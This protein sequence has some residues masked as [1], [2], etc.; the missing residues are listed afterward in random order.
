[1]LQRLNFNTVVALGIVALGA[2]ML[3]VIPNQIAEPPRFFGRSS[4]GLSPKLFPQIVASLFI[5]VG[6][7]YAIASLKMDEP[8]GF[9]GMRGSA[10]VNLGVVLVAMVAYVLL[11]IPIGYVASSVLVAIGISLYY[12]SRSLVGIGLVGILAPFL[13]F[14]VFTSLL[15]VSLP[16]FPRF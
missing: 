15:G 2:W 10:W 11:L 7:I 14:Y 4:T 8:N 16:P 13:I 3:W 6:V 5:V 1:L 12:G 9:A